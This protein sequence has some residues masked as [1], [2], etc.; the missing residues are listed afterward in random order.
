MSNS[1]LIYRICYRVYNIQLM[2]Y[3]LLDEYVLGEYEYIY[4]YYHSTILLLTMELHHTNNIILYC[5]C[6]SVLIATQ[7]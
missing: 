2:G 1:Y 3:G 5:C 4:I 7:C 6:L